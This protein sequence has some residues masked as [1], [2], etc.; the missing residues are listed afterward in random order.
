MKYL[1]ILS[2]ALIALSLMAP[3][4][5]DS[6]LDLA[7]VDVNLVPMD[8]EKVV[9]HQT[10]V[11]HDGMITT[12]GAAA[13]VAIPAGANRILGRGAYLAP[14]LADMHTH[15]SD[16]SDLGIYL[17]NGVTT[18]LHMG[19]TEQRLVGHIRSD[20]A[21]GAVAGPQMFFSLMIDG[22]N[23]FGVLRVETA[24][25]ARDAVR[26]AKANG[27]D[28][29]KVY[30]DLTPGEFSA[31]V[32]EGRRQ[33]LPVI[34]HAVRSVGLP[35]ALFQGQIMVAHAEEFLYTAFTEP[36]SEASVASVVDE[37][38]R[39]GAYVT[40]TLSTYEA[41]SKAW[42]RPEVVS[43][44]LRA[45]EAQYMSPTV[46]LRWDR[47]FYVHRKPE[48][49][50]E[51][52]AFQRRFTLALQRAG[53]PLLAGTDSPEVPGMFPGYSLHLELKNLVASGLTPFQAISAAT[54]TAGEFIHASHPETPRFGTIAVG[55][56]A[57]LILISSNPLRDVAS[58]DRPE[59]VVAGGRWFDRK[60]LNRLLDERR[61][62][63]D[64][65]DEV[66]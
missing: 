25:L 6:A 7:L 26:L 28:F 22:P 13:R 44:W 54:R 24:D 4:R 48:D 37:V 56:R 29:M 58:L 1:L 19:G 16:E 55:N 39:S 62:R 3:A 53:V 52:L 47:S 11:I 8:S 61:H 40:A 35:A 65:L 14:G 20:I 59:G 38:K 34:G 63:Y 50:S 15:V 18:V 45:P 9:P 41:I 30:N 49:L 10:V 57:D 21:R 66:E 12:I 42:G 33:G 36:R 43:G 17:A 27:Y 32:E 46:R 5:A 51:N 23:D 60:G 2:A 64:H 31:L